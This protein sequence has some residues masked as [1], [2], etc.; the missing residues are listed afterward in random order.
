MPL[1]LTQSPAVLGQKTF[2]SDEYG[3]LVLSNWSMGLEPGSRG[4]SYSCDPAAWCESWRPWLLLHPG[5]DICSRWKESERTVSLCSIPERPLH[6]WSM[7]C[8]SWNRE[9]WQDCA[10]HDWVGPRSNL[11]GTKQTR[12]WPSWHQGKG[13]R[14]FLPCWW[15]VSAWDSDLAFPTPTTTHKQR[16]LPW[17]HVPQRK[18]SGRCTWGHND[19]RR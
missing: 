10:K 1:G 11:W 3:T 5:Q 14:L 16:G 17:L 18:G 6:T 8:V 2:P 15:D 7:R 12:P 9:G 13:A 19:S 4:I